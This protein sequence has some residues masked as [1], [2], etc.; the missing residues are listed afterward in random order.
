MRP[1]DPRPAWRFVRG[2]SRGLRM[3]A[4]FPPEGRRPGAAAPLGSEEW[5]LPSPA[6]MVRSHHRLPVVGLTRPLTLLHLSDV[7]LRR[8]SPWVAALC[9]ALRGLSADLVLLTG[10]VVT[11]GWQEAAVRAFLEALPPAR[12]GRFAVM[13]NWEH[14]SGAHPASWGALLAAHGVRLLRDEVVDTGPLR[15]AGTEDL[16]AGVSDPRALRARLPPGPP[17]VVL[18]HSPGMFP[19]LAGPGVSLVLSGHSHGGQVRI[20]GL[21]ALWVP[22]GTGPY[23]AGWYERQGTALFVS[24]GVGWSI[25]PVRTGCPPELAEITLSPPG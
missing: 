13:G 6:G 8:S 5:P 11:R 21:G 10:D 24:R 16:L 19:A 20:P 18:S 12:L 25:A 23:V 2:V 1:P 15:L 17:T 3:G 4:F 7:H 22:R 9:A 14:W